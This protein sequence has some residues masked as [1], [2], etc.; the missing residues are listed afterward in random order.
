MAKSEPDLTEDI[1]T[2]TMSSIYY[3]VML[4]DK[5]VAWAAS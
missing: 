2:S 5:L 1:D 4:F 3:S